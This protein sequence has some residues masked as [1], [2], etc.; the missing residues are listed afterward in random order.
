MLNDW[1]CSI[2]LIKLTE[3]TSW[4]GIT[5][6]WSMKSFWRFLL[7]AFKCSFVD[8]FFFFL[9]SW[10]LPA[11]LQQSLG[12][13]RTPSKSLQGLRGHLITLT[14]SVLKKLYLLV[15]TISSF[16]NFCLNWSHLCV[17]GSM[18]VG[19]PITS[20]FYFQ[21]NSRQEGPQRPITFSEFSAIECC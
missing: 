21:K 14:L 1:F 11:V 20:I 8:F 7:L 4:S 15:I 9:N 10:P 5:G 12:F 16:L 19:N 13:M 18:W 6:M 17:W 3:T 2:S